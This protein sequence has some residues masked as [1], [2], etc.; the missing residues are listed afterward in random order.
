MI[1]FTFCVM[2]TLALDAALHV[3]NLRFCRVNLERIT[4]EGWNRWNECQPET[5]INW[6]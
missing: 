4:E 1:I 2:S 5:E 3:G 6:R